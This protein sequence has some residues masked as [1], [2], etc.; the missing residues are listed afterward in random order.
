MNKN[1]ELDTAQKNLAK[2]MKDLKTAEID[3]DK[4]VTHSA[5]YMGNDEAIEQ[6]RDDKARSAF[7]C[8]ERIKEEIAIQTKLIKRLQNSQ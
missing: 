4:A 8:V 7:M 3:Y 6:I 5:E 2:L 1:T